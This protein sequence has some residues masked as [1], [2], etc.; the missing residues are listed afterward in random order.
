M[1]FEHYY[2][3]QDKIFMLYVCFAYDWTAELC[4]HVGMGVKKINTH[5]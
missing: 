1:D 3:M 5:A 4:C 2:Y